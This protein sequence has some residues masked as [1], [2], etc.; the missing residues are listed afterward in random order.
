MFANLI[1]PG[2]LIGFLLIFLIYKM[3]A[4]SLY[5]A[6]AG[7]VGYIIYFLSQEIGWTLVCV[8]GSFIVIVIILIINATRGV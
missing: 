4:K 1:L 5:L 8:A 2:I 3:G 7:F 6:L